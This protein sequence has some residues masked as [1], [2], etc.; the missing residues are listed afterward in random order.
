VR[1]VVTL[2]YAKPPDLRRGFKDAVGENLGDASPQEVRIDIA[3]LACRDER[4]NRR[5][6]THPRWRSP[7]NSP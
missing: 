6:A 4:R 1:R 5:I 2:T 3:C 7:S